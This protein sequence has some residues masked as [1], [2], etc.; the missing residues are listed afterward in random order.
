MKVFKVFLASIFLIMVMCSFA[1][2]E[3]LELLGNSNECVGTYKFSAFVKMEGSPEVVNGEINITYKEVGR[4]VSGDTYEINQN[5]ISTIKCYENMIVL[6]LKE[7]NTFLLIEPSGTFGGQYGRWEKEGDKITLKGKENDY[8]LT[9]N[10]D[11]ISYEWKNSHKTSYT[12]IE[13]KRAE[14]IEK[15]EYAVFAGLYKFSSM[16][17]ANEEQSVSVSVGQTIGGKTYGEEFFLVDLKSNG[18]CL[19]LADA[20]WGIKD[21]AVALWTIEGEQVAIDYMGSGNILRFTLSD[22]IM[23]FNFTDEEFSVS[24]VLK[25]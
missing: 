1:G 20:M 13:L 10:G 22:N 15:E 11:I 25:K 7:D 14:I 16:T 23:S 9:K 8:V 2:C 17:Q 12:K 4:F 6:D 21:G 3:V 5:G 19:I 24:L 18:E